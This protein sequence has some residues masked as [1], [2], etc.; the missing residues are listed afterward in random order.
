MKSLKQLQLV[1]FLLLVF[2][3]WSQEAKKFKRNYDNVMIEFL[4][5]YDIAFD[6]YYLRFNEHYYS[7]NLSN[8]IFDILDDINN[9]VADLQE[10]LYG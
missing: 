4:N 5:I 2:N 6:E 1:L 9:D 3:M 8:C 10:F 7:E